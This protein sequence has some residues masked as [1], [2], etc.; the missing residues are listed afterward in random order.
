MF[1]RNV[2]SAEDGDSRFSKNVG[3]HPQSHTTSW[4]KETVILIPHTHTQ[5]ELFHVVS[6]VNSRHLIH[7]LIQ[8]HICILFVCVTDHLSVIVTVACV[9]TDHI[10]DFSVP[11][12][13]HSSASQTYPE[14]Y[15]L[16]TY[17][18]IIT[19]FGM[20]LPI[21]SSFGSRTSLLNIV[22]VL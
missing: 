4:P 3:A 15:L 10:Q 13:S 16:I 20:C 5:P 14:H 22:F 8:L 6:S 11:N 1:W 2:L 21:L 9:V 19:T 7:S 12:V 17:V 18:K